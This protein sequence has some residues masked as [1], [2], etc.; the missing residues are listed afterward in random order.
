[1]QS[2]PEEISEILNE[3]ALSSKALTS[4]VTDICWNM[5]GSVTWE[6]AWQL[7]ESQRKVMWTLIKKNVERTEKLGMP[8]L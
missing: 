4:I 5:R 1:L 6:Q 3:M 8:L 2:T 7:T